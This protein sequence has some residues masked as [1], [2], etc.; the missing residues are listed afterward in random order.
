VPR[1]VD[2]VGLLVV[3]LPSQAGLV[4][5]PLFHRTSQAMADVSVWVS[6]SVSKRGL[7]KPLR[8]QLC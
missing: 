2:S 4:L 3:S 7:V 1:L 5:P 6:S 8:K